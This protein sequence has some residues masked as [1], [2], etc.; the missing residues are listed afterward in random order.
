MS[1]GF[2]CCLVGCVALVLLVVALLFVITSLM[3]GL[4]GA[5]LAQQSLDRE[6]YAGMAGAHRRAAIA[7]S[8]SLWQI[9]TVSV[10]ENVYMHSNV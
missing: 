8:L 5:H 4:C 9:F 6:F 10:Q 2:F 3:L 7:L 1:V